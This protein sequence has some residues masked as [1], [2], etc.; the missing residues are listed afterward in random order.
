MKTV[1]SLL[2]VA[3]AALGAAQATAQSYPAKPIRM[4]APSGAGGPVDVI[5]RTVSQRLGQVLKQQIIVENRVGAA[6][7][8]GTEYV[9]KQ[10]PDGYT[11]LFGF[12]GPLA[13]VPNF[14][15]NTPYDPLRDL[16]PVSQV[17][18]APYVLLVH[19]SVPATTVKQLVALAKG[20]PGQMNFA[21]GGNGV[22][23][24]MAGELFKFMAQ[25][26]IVHVPYKG[27]S[28]ARNDIL[29]GQIEMMFDAITT[30]APN[31]QSGRVKALATTGR[32]R[33][34]VLPNVPTVGEA[35]VTGYE[36]TIWLGIMAPSGTPKPVI[37][38][39]NAEINK[40]LARSE[41]KEQWAKQGATPMMMSPAEFETY[42]KADIDKWGGVVKAANIKVE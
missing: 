32:E 13:I 2:F 10:P 38:K 33:S 37:D 26:D 39:L 23:I 8:I 31:V 19:P 29:G 18:A 30:M 28:G 11:L 15:P 14:N 5:C 21:S 27:S 36:A 24:H 17:A 22:G 1:A 20:R 12:S 35:G 25:V 34:A 9:T 16:V 4:V 42:L 41:L 7:L 3:A 40:V 6:G